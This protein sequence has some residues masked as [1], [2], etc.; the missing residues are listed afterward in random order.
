MTTNRLAQSSD[1]KGGPKVCPVDM[2]RGDS[3]ADKAARER[4]WIDVGNAKL[5]T[6]GK[7]HLE[8]RARDGHY[9]LEA[10]A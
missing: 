9:W 7:H 5:W 10:R 4:Y 3:P 8:W 2:P 1:P 6:A